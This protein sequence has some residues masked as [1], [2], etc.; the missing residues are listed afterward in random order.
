MIK[1]KKARRS[2]FTLFESHWTVLVDG[3]FYFLGLL[4]RQPFLPLHPQFPLSGMSISAM[5][6]D[7]TQV[8]FCLSYNYGFRFRRSSA[9]HIR[10]ILPCVIWWRMSFQMIL[11]W[12]HPS[13]LTWA[14]WV[15]QVSVNRLL[16]QKKLFCM[17]NVS[18]S[19]QLICLPYLFWKIKEA[20]PTVAAAK[21]LSITV[22]RTRNG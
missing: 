2:A 18:A 7:P 12:I 6:V 17:F 22:Q 4:W 11:N 20:A 16:S 10:L 3:L 9:S 15:T 13:C 19:C 1:I 8:S 21:S 14:W 5:G